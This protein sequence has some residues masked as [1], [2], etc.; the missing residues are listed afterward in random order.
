MHP[1]DVAGAKILAKKGAEAKC[2]FSFCIAPIDNQGVESNGSFL[3]QGVGQ[4]AK[5][6]MHGTVGLVAEVVIAG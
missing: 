4:G 3:E 2:P 5:V 6:R 1:K